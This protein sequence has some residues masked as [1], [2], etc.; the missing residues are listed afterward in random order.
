MTIVAAWAKVF[1]NG[2]A[3]RVQFAS[4]GAARML[5]YTAGNWWESITDDV[6]SAEATPTSPIK[7]GRCVTRPTFVA[8]SAP[9]SA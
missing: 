8:A 3:G 1:L 5:G 7:R 9:H 4:S 2:T 6:A